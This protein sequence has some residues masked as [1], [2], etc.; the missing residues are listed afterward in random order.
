MGGGEEVD[1]RFWFPDGGVASEEEVVDVIAVVLVAPVGGTGTGSDG[2]MVSGR[3]AD[4]FVDD[5]DILESWG[6]GEVGIGDKSVAA[7]IDAHVALILQQHEFLTNIFVWLN[8][9]DPNHFCP[10]A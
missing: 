1:G 4:I 2:G 9:D 10:S 5:K 7:Q 8:S 6:I 3:D